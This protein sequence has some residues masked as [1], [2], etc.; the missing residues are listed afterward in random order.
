MSF[1][2][3]TAQILGKNGSLD[4]IIVLALFAGAVLYGFFL[5]RNK[6]VIGIIATY[7][8]LVLSPLFP[9][10]VLLKKNIEA[11]RAYAVDIGIFLG[12]VLLLFLLLQRSVVRTA[13][14]TPR[15]GDGGLIQVVVFSI[16]AVGL[17][18]AYSY[19]LLPSVLKS[20]TSPVLQRFI[21]SDVALF[22]W[23]IAPLVGLL[24]VRG[25]GAKS[26]A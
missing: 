4:V 11:D 20:A 8:A 3:L 12:L 25:R 7:L 23:T 10:A 14:R 6:L 19:S 24:L 1:D 13:L 22:W 17:I 21:F 2:Q 15:P 16:L 5:G 9:F 18:V 26:D